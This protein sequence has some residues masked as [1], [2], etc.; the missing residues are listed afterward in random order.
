MKCIHVYNLVNLDTGPDLSVLN[1][2]LPHYVMS[3]QVVIEI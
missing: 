3:I 2:H 1:A